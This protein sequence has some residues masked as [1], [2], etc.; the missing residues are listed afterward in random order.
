MSLMSD[1]YVTS[2]KITDGKIVLTVLVNDFAEPGVFLEI[3]GQAIQTGGAF[4][5][6][7]DMQPVPPANGNPNDPKDKDNHYV[8]VT[9]APSPHQFR[10]GEDVSV[11]TRVARI[12]LSVLGEQSQPQ[13]SDPSQSSESSQSSQSSPDPTQPAGE[14][15]T[16]NVKRFSQVNGSSW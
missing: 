16:W 13:P 6:F 15:M 12:W 5:N 7:Y 14:G 10:K 2:A 9:G 8:Y 3:S 11:V 4:A 1:P